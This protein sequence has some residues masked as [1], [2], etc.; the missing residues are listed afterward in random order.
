MQVG[1]IIKAAEEYAETHVEPELEPY[2][3]GES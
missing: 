2:M 3:E 1:A